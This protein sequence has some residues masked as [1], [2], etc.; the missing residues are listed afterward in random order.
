MKNGFRQSM[1]W[2]HTWTGLVVGWIL[3]FVFVTG[4]LG[5]FDTE[6]DQWMKPEAIPQEVSLQQELTAAQQ[7]LQQQ[8]GNAERW[9]IYP[10]SNRDTPYLRITWDT[11]PQGEQLEIKRGE[12]FLD[13]STAQPVDARATGGGQLLYKMHYAL[14]YMPRSV[15]N[16]IIGICSMF[17]LVAIISGV[18]THKKIFADFF[19][20]RPNKGQRSWLDLHAVL[21]VVTLPFFLMITYSGLIFFVFTLIPGILGANYGF[22]EKNRQIFNDELSAREFRSERANMEVSLASLN[23]MAMVAENR[24]GEG[25]VRTLEVSYPGDANARVRITRQIG[26]PLRSTEELIFM[27]SSGD[28]L[29]DQAAASVVPR[30]FYETLLGLHESLF[31]GWWLRWLYFL[32]G[33]IGAAIIGS[34]LILWVVKRR[35]KQLKQVA[36]PDFGHRLVEGLNVGTIVGLHIAIAA[37]FFAN[38]LLPIDLLARSEWEVHVLFIVWFAAFLHPLFRPI[39]RAWIEQL[40][41]AAIAF[42]LLPLINA[43]TTERGPIQSLMEG[44][45]VFAGFDLVALTAAGLFAAAAV[46]LQQREKLLAPDLAQAGE[47]RSAKRKVSRTQPQE[48][49]A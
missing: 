39:N 33:L 27:G 12:E 32:S 43:L 37:Y 47:A 13:A 34:G 24:W 45:W 26:S 15:S 19:T 40:W 35:P 2:L 18:I 5:R 29:G 48:V 23:A 44:D 9:T 41:I 8:A 14:H 28:L 4:N 10:T 22:G 11:K 49:G 16:W 20:F 6:I 31:A 1:A 3:F 46:K 17:M 38:R 30:T 21:A 42:L 25:Q 36:G 7:R